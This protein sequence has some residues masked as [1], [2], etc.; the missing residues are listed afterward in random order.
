MF[1]KQQNVGNISGLA[2]SHN[3]PLQLPRRAVSHNPKIDDQQFFHLLYS[4]LC[5]L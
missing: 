1:A 3:A 2:C 5:K 4:F